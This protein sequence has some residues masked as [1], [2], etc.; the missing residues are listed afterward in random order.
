MEVRFVVVD[1]G[2][3][4]RKVFVVVGE[5]IYYLSFRKFRS[6]RKKIRFCFWVFG[7]IRFRKY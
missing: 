3:E 7:N 2:G 5:I 1:T 6:L 4:E